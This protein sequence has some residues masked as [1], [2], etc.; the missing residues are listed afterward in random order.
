M[1]RRGASVRVGMAEQAFLIRN[2]HAADDKF[3]AFNQL[4]YV[5]A[6]TDSEITHLAS[7]NSIR[8]Q[9]MIRCGAI[10]FKDF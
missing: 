8:S 10:P 9:S 7:L 4:M 2:S 1:K 3:A 5:K 6:L